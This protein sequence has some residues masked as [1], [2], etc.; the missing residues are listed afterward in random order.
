MSRLPF[1]ALKPP[2]LAKAFVDGDLVPT[3][4]ENHICLNFLGVF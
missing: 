4:I 3:L 2:P 1:E